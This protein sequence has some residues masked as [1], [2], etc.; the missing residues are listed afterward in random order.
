MKK[1]KQK[2]IWMAVGMLAA[3]ALWTVA[4]RLVDVKAIGPGGSNVGFASLNGFFHGLTGVHMGLYT[5][6]DWLGLVPLFVAM[7]FAV[8]GFAQWIKRK[9]LLKVDRSILVLG[10]FYVVVVALYVFF[11][12]VVVNYRP[13]LINGFLEASYP[14]STTLLVL[15]VMPTAR[16]QLK[17]RIKN[18]VLKKWVTVGINAFIVFMVV[19]RLVSGVH[20]LTD[21]VGGILLSGGLVMMYDALNNLNTKSGL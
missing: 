14:S 20:W 18:N 1:E 11:E 16:M 15:C 10:G 13:V 2:K 19:G 9:N 3:F 5:I 6:T 12:E 21:I 17:D 4:V 8:L 7:G